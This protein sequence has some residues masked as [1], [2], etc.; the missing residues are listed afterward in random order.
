MVRLVIW[1]ATVPILTSLYATG[2]FETY[3]NKIQLYIPDKQ[4]EKFKILFKPWGLAVTPY[5]GID[6][7]QNLIR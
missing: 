3:L 5:C 6:L 2:P 4:L 1:D 7:G